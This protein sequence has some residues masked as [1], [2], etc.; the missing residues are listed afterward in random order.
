MLIVLILIQ[1]Y[2]NIRIKPSANL[3]LVTSQN[4]L[5]AAL[6][7]GDIHFLPEEDTIAMPGNLE[8]EPN[9]MCKH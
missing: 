9:Y 1:T 3:L 4:K 7:T 6:V 8:I 2:Q 5:C